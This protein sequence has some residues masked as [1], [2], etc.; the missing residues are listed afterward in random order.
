[1]RAPAQRSRTTKA[2]ASPRRAAPAKME[3][4]A[5]SPARASAKRPSTKASSATSSAEGHAAISG[6]HCLLHGSF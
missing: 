3:S 5:R 2:H 1:M 6:S 4:T